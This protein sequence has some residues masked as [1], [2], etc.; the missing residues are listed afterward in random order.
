MT[1]VVGA[2]SYVVD[3]SNKSAACIQH[4]VAYIFK[5]HA[6]ESDALMQERVISDF[7]QIDKRSRVSTPIARPASPSYPHPITLWCF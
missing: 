1:I 6:G 3:M 2:N 5:R 7:D 4:H